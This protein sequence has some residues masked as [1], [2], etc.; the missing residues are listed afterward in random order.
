MNLFQ[1]HPRPFL[2]DEDEPCSGFTASRIVLGTDFVTDISLF[3]LRLEA[4]FSLRPG[5]AETNTALRTICE[6][7]A[8]A[9]C[10]MLEIESG[11]ILAEYRPS[12]TLGGAAGSEVEVFIYDTLSGGAGFSTQLA[13][14]A[15][16]LFDLTLKILS[17]C[18]EC[19]D[20]SCYRCLRSFRNKLDHRFLDRKLGEQL[21]RAALQGGYPEYPADRVDSSL[22][23]LFKDLDRQLS[24]L[25]RFQRDVLRTA[26]DSSRVMVPILA[27]RSVDGRESWI[28]LSSPVAAGVPVD[29]ALRAVDGW[30]NNPIICVDDLMVRRHLPAAVKELDER[31]R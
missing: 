3:A 8:K 9:A 22:T 13:T 28:A 1:A 31:L 11:E 24:H 29:A 18:P 12:F 6:A 4:P 26:P 17:K 27:T 30:P 20:A 23:I 21:L 2:S 16:A 14:R 7:V 25:F 5:N 19:C 10:R 15:A